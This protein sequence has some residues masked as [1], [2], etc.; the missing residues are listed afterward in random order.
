MD[1]SSVIDE[2]KPEWLKIDCVI[3]CRRKSDS[4]KSCQIMKICSS[5]GEI[6]EFEF[7]VK[8]M[9]LDY[10]NSTWESSCNEELLAE[11]GRLIQ[12]HQ[13]A[14]EIVDNSSITSGSKSQNE[15]PDKLYGGT[16][17]NYQLQGLKWVLSNFKAR[18]NV[19]LAGMLC[20]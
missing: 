16:L 5:S 7:L 2:R 9:G 11:V 18:R 12:R 19:I 1:G 14:G 20:F 4:D 8:W 15:T 13:R 3:A 17:Y 10:K 6:G